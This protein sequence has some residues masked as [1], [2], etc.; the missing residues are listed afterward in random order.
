MKVD[1]FSTPDLSTPDFSTIKFST[2]KFCHKLRSSA[3]IIEAADG[4]A[5]VFPEHKFLIVE[6][7]QQRGYL[8]IALSVMASCCSATSEACRTSCMTDSSCPSSPSRMSSDCDSDVYSASIAACC[9]H[10]CWHAQSCCSSWTRRR[11]PWR[12]PAGSPRGGRPRGAARATRIRHAAFVSSSSHCS[13]RLSCR[14]W[15]RTHRPMG[16]PML[17]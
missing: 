8:V 12:A 2:M 4:F 16:R 17:S 7:L 14:G 11:R 1:D 9:L 3:A 6:A 10:C 15:A 5:G 13:G